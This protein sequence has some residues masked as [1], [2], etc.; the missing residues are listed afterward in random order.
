MQVGCRCCFANSRCADLTSNRMLSTRCST[1]LVFVLAYHLSWHTA[2]AA[3]ICLQQTASG[4]LV[5]AAVELSGSSSLWGSHA[6]LAQIS[7]CCCSN[8]RCHH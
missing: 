3:T 5:W 2:C 8:D 1:V 6:L 7:S 4:V